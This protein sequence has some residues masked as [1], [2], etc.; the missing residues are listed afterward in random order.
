MKLLSRRGKIFI[1]IVLIAAVLFLNFFQKETK[2]FFYTLS[3]PLQ[4]SFRAAGDKISGFFGALANLDELKKTS[5][6]SQRIAQELLVEKAAS[7]ELKK[8]NETL[9]EALQIGLQK[10]F[11]LAL[12]EMT[13]K[14]IGQESILINQGA[15]NGLALGMP[16]VTE[17]RV[18]LGRISEVFDSF[19]RVT[20]ISSKDSVFD[21]K[22]AGTDTAG[23]ARG[24]GSESIEFDLVP[25]EKVLQENDMV[26]SSSLGG[27]YPEGLLAG[28][29][30]KVSKNDVSPF[31]RAE[32]APL[33]NLQNSNIV[34]VILDFTK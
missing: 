19:S 5:D 17:E 28:T 30:K 1:L 9:R 20:L 23:V 7:A 27:V 34:F 31:Y 3:S 10:D 15:K 8:E 25:Q 18:L 24:K 32:I 26:V 14:D 22:V 13:G 33:F 11:R 29:V 21:A 6:E 12:V 2:G 4:I 16:V